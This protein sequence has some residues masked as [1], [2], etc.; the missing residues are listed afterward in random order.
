MWRVG[1]AL[2]TFV[3]DI[4][5]HLAEGADVNANGAPMIGGEVIEAGC[6]VNALDTAV[7]LHL[8]LVE[9]SLSRT[10]ANTFVALR[11]KIADPFVGILF[12]NWQIGDVGVSGV[13]AQ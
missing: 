11:A 8:R 10:F 2:E 1:I 13:D 7:P 4:V 6:A 9:D 12:L 3:N 5:A